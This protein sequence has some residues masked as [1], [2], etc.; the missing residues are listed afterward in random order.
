[1]KNKKIYWRLAFLL[2]LILAITWIITFLAIGKL[3]SF[4]HPDN[5][6]YE[7]YIKFLPTWALNRWLDIP[8][9]FLIVF[10]IHNF[11]SRLKKVWD[12]NH[13]KWI[14]ILVAIVITIG[15]VW[16]GFSILLTNTLIALFVFVATI[17]VAS[18]ILYYL[19]LICI[20]FKSLFKSLVLWAIE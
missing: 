3:P 1:M 10:I 18:C 13:S 14:S 16:I 11:P 7:D 19:Q 15:L 20:K 8:G 4:N 5:V 9:I 12:D 6:W 17:M 2:S